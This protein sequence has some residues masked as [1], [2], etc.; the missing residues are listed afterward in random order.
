[1]ADTTTTT[2]ALVKPEIGTSQDT[3]GTKI[4]DNLDKIDDLLDGTLTLTSINST[5]ILRGGSQV[6]SRNNILG[7]VTQSGGV[8]TGA[9]V[10][11]GSNANGR[12]VRFAD[13]TQ[14]CRHRLAAS[15][16]ANTTWTFPVAFVSATDIDVQGTGSTGLLAVRNFS[17]AVFPTT[18]AVEFNVF[19]G[20]GARTN[21]TAFLRAEGRWF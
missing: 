6:Y 9:I 11:S 19:D 8:P 5:N 15:T 4:N 21:S 3:W 20:A 7:T 2:Y 17:I 18:T 10:E 14:I 12:F 16:S 13:G 1:M